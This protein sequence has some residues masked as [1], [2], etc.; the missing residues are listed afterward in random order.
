M[1]EQDKARPVSGEIMAG[2]HDDREPARPA[3]FAEAEFETVAAPPPP[4]AARFA[5]APP[6][7]GMDLLRQGPAG[8]A[9]ATAQRGGPLFWIFGLMLVA[10][11]F[12]V[13]GGHALV[14]HQASMLTP[15]ET[16]QPLRIADVTS[17]VETHGE[18]QVLFVEGR[19]EN[20]GSRAL[21]LPGMEIA[22]T[23]N[24]GAVSRYALSTSDTEL[25][26]GGRYSFSSRLV[27]PAGGVKSVAVT[28]VE[29]RR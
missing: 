1:S 10:L 21:T 5:D 2:S 8:A 22:V 26:A 28:F 6:A 13:S 15:A 18:R 3:E 29:D 14:R 27:A 9:S 4:Q 7:A 17:R 16:R 19:A 24:D 23:G 25:D 11:A 12:W 20:K